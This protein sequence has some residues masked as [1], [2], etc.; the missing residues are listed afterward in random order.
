MEGNSE[1]VTNVQ[2]WVIEY[3]DALFD[4]AYFKTSKREVAED[5][6]QDTFLA[7]FQSYHTFKFESNPKSW[8]NTILNNKIVDYY[9]K[10]AAQA[11]VLNGENN[12]QAYAITESFF[13]QNDK[14]KS[15]PESIWKD[16]LHLL[17]DEDFNGVMR[18]CLED[19]PETWRNAISF[20][21]LFSRDLK[22]ICQ[23]LN[24]SMSNY[25]QVIHRAKL[26]LKK[27][28]E[29]KYFNQL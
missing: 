26:M 1:V 22:E 11:T 6:V 5:L 20:K 23:E 8:L 15:E 14:W 28:L 9:R 27:C 18:T 3:S 24:L 2:S 25:W 13:D 29:V 12:R 17:D 4:W 16:D 10:S 21:Y 7:A 19:L